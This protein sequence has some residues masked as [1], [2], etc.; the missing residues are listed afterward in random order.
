MFYQLCFRI[1]YPDFLREFRNPKSVIHYE[2]VPFDH[3]LFIMY[4]SGTTGKP[5]CMVH[6]AGVRT[7][8]VPLN[9]DNP[10]ILWRN[11]NYSTILLPKSI[12]RVHTYL[13]FT[14]NP[15]EAPRRAYISKWSQEVR[16]HL[17]LHN[18]EW[19]FIIEELFTYY[20]YSKMTML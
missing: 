9:T 20:W 18:C 16:R 4:S 12:N 11:F 2:Q 17:L 5:K 7:N 10:W 14:G 19:N 3:P 13:Y 1:S 6:S 8:T 15:H